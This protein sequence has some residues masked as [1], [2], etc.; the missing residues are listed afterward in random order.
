MTP[1]TRVDRVVEGDAFKA[2]AAPSMV[3]R[4]RFAEGTGDMDVECLGHGLVGGGGDG[5]HRRH[6]VEQ[7]GDRAPTGVLSLPAASVAVAVKAVSPFGKGD[8]GQGELPRA[9]APTVPSRLRDGG[10]G[11]L[12]AKRLTVESASALPERTVVAILVGETGWTSTGGAGGMVSRV[13]CTRRRADVAGAV[14]RL[15]LR[16]YCPFPPAPRRR[17]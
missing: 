4:G 8:S 3:K 10:A 12:R 7:N 16:W 5:D 15:E 9:S 1:G 13:P 14:D 6:G 2:T 17:G 11:R